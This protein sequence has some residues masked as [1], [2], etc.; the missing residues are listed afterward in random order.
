MKKQVFRLLKI[1]FNIF[2]SIL[3]ISLAGCS[4]SKYAKLI[5]TETAKGIVHDSLFLGLKFGQT[6]Q[7][8]F[9]ICLKLNQDKIVT[10]GGVKMSVKYLLPTKKGDDPR[11]A[12]TMHFYG[13]FNKE[14]V[15]TG[16]D[17]QF[18][19][20][21]WSLWNKSLQSYNLIHAV[22]DTLRSWYPGND[23]LKVEMKKNNGNI[24]VKIDG[25]RRIIIKP[26]DDN[27]TVKVLIDDLRTTLD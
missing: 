6:N 9:A 24:F 18:S 23:F 10:N 19:Y 11:Y 25:N 4:E 14:K 16:M 5:K 7:E 8:F 27:E 12:T 13:I 3:F 26:L 20:N 22:K 21:A 17:I 15:M 2:I 1:S